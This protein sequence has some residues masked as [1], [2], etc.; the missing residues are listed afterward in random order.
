[1]ISRYGAIEQF[2]PNVLGQSRAPA[3]LFKELATLRTD[4]ALFAKIDD[5]EWRG[6]TAEFALLCEQLQAPDLLARVTKIAQPKV[7]RR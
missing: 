2:P 4:A 1:M 3:L 6:P 7:L 5:L